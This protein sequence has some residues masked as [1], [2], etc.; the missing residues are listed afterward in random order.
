MC[1][2]PVDFNNTEFQD[3]NVGAALKQ[4]RH[5][6]SALLALV[7]TALSE[8]VWNHLHCNNHL[9]GMQRAPE[10]IIGRQH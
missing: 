3:L 6:W 7:I 1:Q 8:S 9:K 10:A 2:G 5:Y 4:S